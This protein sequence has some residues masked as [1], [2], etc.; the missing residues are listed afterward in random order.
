MFRDIPL[1][2]LKWRSLDACV[3][4]ACFDLS[5][6][7][8]IVVAG[9]FAH[10]DAFCSDATCGLATN[11]LKRRW[12]D[13]TQSFRRLT[14]N[15]WKWVAHY[16]PDPTENMM[17]SQK[18]I[19]FC[20]TFCPNVLVILPIWGWVKSQNHSK[21][22]I[23]ITTW[24]REWLSKNSSYDLGY[25]PGNRLDPHSR[26]VTG[27]SLFVSDLGN[28][29]WHVDRKATPDSMVGLKAQDHGSEVAEE[30]VISMDAMIIMVISWDI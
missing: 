13:V 5:Y 3:K 1:E 11:T 22:T 30:W 23:E 2:R 21:I 18:V 6:Y 15:T 4:L 7:G 24:F 17:A 14:R 27:V 9:G 12:R 10:L 20:E 16:L 28:H 25:H 8:R 26:G 19:S 29:G